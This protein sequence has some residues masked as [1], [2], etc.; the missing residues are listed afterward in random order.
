MTFTEGGSAMPVEDDARWFES[1]A[2]SVLTS[3]GTDRRTRLTPASAAG[4]RAVVAGLA[5][6]ARRAS[7]REL[8]GEQVDRSATGAAGSV[9]GREQPEWP[10]PATA[11]DLPEPAPP[12]WTDHVGGG[13]LSPLTI[14]PWHRQDPTGTEPTR[15][16][17][18]AGVQDHH[19]AG[20]PT[21]DLPASRA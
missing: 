8:L 12:R 18:R 10:T 19:A 4:L 3:T 17:D 7:R 1:R 20:R 16:S 6:A 14:A 21:Q 2:G 9:R 13:L 11:D 15:R 5:A